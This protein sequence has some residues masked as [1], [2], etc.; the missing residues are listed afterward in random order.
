MNDQEYREESLQRLTRIETLV[1]D[2][3]ELRKQV[4]NLENWR[5]YITGGL[6]IIYIILGFLK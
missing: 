6:A 4:R 1:A 3:P 2:L 5:M